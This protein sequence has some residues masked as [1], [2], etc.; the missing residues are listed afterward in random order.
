MSKY[1][2]EIKKLIESIDIDEN[3]GATYSIKVDKNT[4]GDP[5][6]ILLDS[7]NNVIAKIDYKTWLNLVTEVRTTIRGESPKWEL[8]R[9][10]K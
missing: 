4:V 10:H 2:D 9:K 1:G 5:D 7:S 8:P 3:S 6:I